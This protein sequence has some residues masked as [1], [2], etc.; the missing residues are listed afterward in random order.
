MTTIASLVVVPPIAI[1][2]A[3]LVSSTVPE[4]DYTEWSGATTYALDARCMTVANHNIYQ[5]LQAGNVNK[6]PATEPTWWVSVTP[7]NRWKAFD[8][9]NSTQTAQASS[10]QYVLELGQ[11]VDYV[12]LLNIT[13]GTTLRT[14]VVDPD[15][16]S[17]Y[18]ETVYLSRIL[19]EASWYAFF[20]S[21]KRS[22]SSAILTDLPPYPNAVTTIDITGDAGLAFGILALGQ[23]KQI[24]QGV[25]YGAKVSIQDYSRKETNLWGDTVLVKRAYAKRASFN[26]RLNSVEVDTVNDY[27]AQLRATPCLWI[28]SSGYTSTMVFGIYENFE[29]TI[30]YFDSSDCSLNLLGLT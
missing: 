8:T 28:G 20:I 4:T 6:S 12:G 7:T 2:D 29:T 5:S 18:D 14:R 30:Q 21:T 19:A 24:G 9:S 11:I 13:D 10:A 15:Y 26:V 27:L 22:L 23:S 3:M 16:G 17:V 1:T 25:S